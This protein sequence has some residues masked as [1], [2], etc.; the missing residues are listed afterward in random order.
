VDAFSQLVRQEKIAIAVR[1][2]PV[3]VFVIDPITYNVKHALGGGIRFFGV[4]SQQIEKMSIRDWPVAFE[5][6][7]RLLG[8]L[9]AGEA[10]ASERMT[11]AGPNGRLGFVWSTVLT[12]YN[13]SLAWSFM[14]AGDAVHD[15]SE[16]LEVRSG[17]TRA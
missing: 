15:D 4:T 12:R 11:S 14:P 16:T 10:W 3:C 6:F 7:K 2:S 17:G 13:G 9:E 8:R 1:L 5:S